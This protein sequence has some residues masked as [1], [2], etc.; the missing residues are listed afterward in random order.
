MPEK[1]L[2]NDTEKRTYSKVLVLNTCWYGKNILPSLN[3]MIS[4]AERHPM[5]YNRL[6]NNLNTAL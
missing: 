1:N 3:N 5:S 6:K 4:E 2:S